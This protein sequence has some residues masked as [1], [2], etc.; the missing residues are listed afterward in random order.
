M[1]KL[2]SCQ[3]FLV[4]EE[5]FIFVYNYIIDTKLH[6]EHLHHMYLSVWGIYHKQVCCIVGVVTDLLLCVCVCRRDRGERI[7]VQELKSLLRTL[8]GSTA[9]MC[10]CMYVYV[11]YVCMYVYGHQT[12][13]HSTLP[14]LP[15]PP[16]AAILCTLSS[17]E[18]VLPNVFASCAADWSVKI[19]DHELQ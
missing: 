18:S 6:P 1:K 8:S 11:Q 14:P 9:G 16:R 4:T 2:E 15:S 3:T 7:Y 5:C 13:S 12:S 10:I 17:G 19:W